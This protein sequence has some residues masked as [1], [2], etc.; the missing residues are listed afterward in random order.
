MDPQR[1]SLFRTWPFIMLCLSAISAVVLYGMRDR[2]YGQSWFIT[3]IAVT[4]VMAVTPLRGWASG[5]FQTPTKRGWNHIL[6]FGFGTIF[7]GTGAFYMGIVE[8]D[9]KIALGL[10]AVSVINGYAALATRYQW[11]GFRL[12]PEP[13]HCAGCGYN[14]TGN[15]SGVC[16]EC[17]RT[18]DF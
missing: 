7:A 11:P 13:G 5:F 4:A 16:P 18:V 8:R 10:G 9:W 15:Q 6:L 14:M 2:F 17:G 1:P 12:P 3:A